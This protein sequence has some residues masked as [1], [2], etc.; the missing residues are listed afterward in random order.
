MRGNCINTAFAPG[1]LMW[2]ALN[3]SPCRM[4]SA[5]IESHLAATF[6]V[7][8]AITCSNTATRSNHFP[9]ELSFKLYIIFNYGQ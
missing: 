5:L 2:A 8:V 4:A 7:K 6:A 3:A 9:F 1:G